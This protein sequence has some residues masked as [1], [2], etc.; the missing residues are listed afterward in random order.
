MKT[1]LISTLAAVLSFTAASAQVVTTTTETTA[2]LTTAKGTVTTFVPG[3]NMVVQETTGPVTYIH[4]PDASYVFK[5]I[6]LTPAEAQ[7]RIRAG[8]PVKVEYAP[9]GNTRVVKRVIIDEDAKVEI[10]RDDDEVEI[11]VDD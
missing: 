7:A 9:Q 3:Q 10:D 4:N 2:G 11:E 6:P 1:L 5:G 8:L